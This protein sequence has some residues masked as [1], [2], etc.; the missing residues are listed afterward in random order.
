MEKSRPSGFSLVELA[1]VLSIVVVLALVLVPLMIGRL[2]SSRS[3]RA[4]ADVGE[5]AKAIG[6]LRADTTVS[7]AGCVD[8]QANL[9]QSS[10]D[11]PPAC[12]PT[13]ILSSAFGACSQGNAGNPCWGGPYLSTVP[14]DPWGNAYYVTLNTSNY[15]VTV[16][17]EGPDGITATTDDLTYVQ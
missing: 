3:A 7:G 6:R 14:I 4:Q 15:L 13:G 5:L 2:E 1:I 8:V 17:S 10:T 16:G 12:I 9:T 11:V